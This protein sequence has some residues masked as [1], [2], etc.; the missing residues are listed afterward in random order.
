MK[1]NI[2]GDARNVLD[3]CDDLESFQVACELLGLNLAYCSYTTGGV[4][5]IDV[6]GCFLEDGTFYP[7]PQ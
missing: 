1:M 7:F 6:D 5:Y 3:C 4:E 2:I